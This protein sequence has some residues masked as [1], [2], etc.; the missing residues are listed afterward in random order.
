M[1][2]SKF[3]LRPALALGMVAAT[4]TSSSS[5]LAMDEV[6]C[7]SV[8][9]WDDRC[10]KSIYLVFGPIKQRI[11]ISD[12]EA[13]A[14]D[15]KMT[16]TIKTLVSA[17]KQKADTL[18]GLLTLE[19]GLPAKNLYCLVYSPTGDELARGLG[20]SIRTHRRTE[21]AKAIQAALMLSASDDDKISILEI[22]QK[23]PL[24][25]MYF[26]VSGIRSTSKQLEGMSSSLQELLKQAE[27]G[28]QCFSTKLPESTRRSL[29]LSP[30]PA[31]TVVPRRRPVAAPRPKPPVRGLW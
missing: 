10:D 9:P 1:K 28:A 21:S 19:I 13:F 24:P 26:D 12:L 27:E 3:L 7:N 8:R 31:S 20:K 2:L 5:V 4:I 29:T 11:P 15:G 30:R 18:R 22:L 25:G 17:S 23:Y 14:K 6:F 16:M